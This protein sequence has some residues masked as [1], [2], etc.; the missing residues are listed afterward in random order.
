MSPTAYTDYKPCLQ[1]EMII[2]CCLEALIGIP[3]SWVKQTEKTKWKQKKKLTL[4]EGQECVLGTAQKLEE[5]QDHKEG[6]ILGW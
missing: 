2:Q 5:V 1:W 6:H 4:C 3:D